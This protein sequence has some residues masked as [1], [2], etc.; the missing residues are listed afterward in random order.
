MLISLRVHPLSRKILLQEQGPEP[1]KFKR[2]DV[3]LDLLRGACFSGPGTDD[4]PA[5]IADMLTI[6][7][8]DR[9]GAALQSAGYAPG[10]SLYRHHRD[11]L[12]RYIWSATLSG[13]QATDAMEAFY[14]SYDLTDDD[15]SYDTCYRMYQRFRMDMDELFSKKSVRFAARGV[16]KIGRAKEGVPAPQLPNAKEL[17]LCVET[18]ASLLRA[19]DPRT[20][21]YLIHQVEVYLYRTYGCRSAKWCARHF[22]RSPRRIRAAVQRVR[23]YMEVDAG[24]RKTIMEAVLGLKK[25]EQT[26]V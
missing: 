17:A 10:L 16:L 20:P 23:G 11:V 24:F 13:L 1:I 7:V 19:N 5:K 2:N 4:Q 3:I 15:Y 8:P 6:D 18:A 26:P 22:R 21:R 9:L 25:S 12:M 14:H